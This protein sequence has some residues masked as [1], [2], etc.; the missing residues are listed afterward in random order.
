MSIFD[1]VGD[2]W[3]VKLEIFL[4]LG[5]LVSNKGTT[6]KRRSGVVVVE[7]E[8]MRMERKSVD[9]VAA[10]VGGWSVWWTRG[11]RMIFSNLTTYS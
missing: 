8:L 6:V 10:G 5:Y 9:G 7:V 4:D 1:L 2:D 11:A 3:V